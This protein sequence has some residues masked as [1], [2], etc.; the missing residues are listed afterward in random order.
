MIKMNLKKHYVI[1]ASLLLILSSCSTKSAEE[2]ADEWCAL[3]NKIEL[4]NPIDQLSLT[5]Q[6]KALEQEIHSVYG[7]DQEQMNLIY[8]RTDECD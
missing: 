5:E 3:N 4:A 8:A 2:Y 6:A 7:E 1:V